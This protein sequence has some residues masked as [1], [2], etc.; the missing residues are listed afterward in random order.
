MCYRR[1]CERKFFY[2]KWCWENGIGNNVVRENAILES[3]AGEYCCLR[4]C[5]IIQ[6]VWGNACVE[7]LF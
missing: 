6:N 3:V 4:K 7:T 1:E 2:R 5:F